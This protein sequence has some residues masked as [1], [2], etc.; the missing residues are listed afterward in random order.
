MVMLDAPPAGPRS[1]AHDRRLRQLRQNAR[2][3]LRL[4]ADVALLT[5]HHASH[6]PV[7]VTA[8]LARAGPGWRHEAAALR[9]QI[10][11]LRALVVALM[12][13]HPHV[14]VEGLL[15]ATPS[16]APSATSMDVEDS[17]APPPPAAASAVPL[18]G[19]PQPVPGTGGPPSSLCI[20]CGGTGK[21][22]WGPC[23]ACALPAASVAPTPSAA[24]SAAAADPPAV[25]RS[26]TRLFFTEESVALLRARRAARL[27][28]EA[29][30]LARASAAALEAE[31]TLV[32]GDVATG[33]ALAEEVRRLQRERPDA[34]AQWVS[35][36]GET[37]GGVMDPL[38][39]TVASLRRFL[40]MV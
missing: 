2:V 40:L 7:L 35:Y 29:A 24:A 4:A 37:L 36:C 22:G 13:A 18:G 28:S 15:P 26:E 12:A 9:E 30:L 16:A 17:E 31:R 32:A 3:R 8:P 39:H 19:P 5:A 14:A 20:A 23:K 38:K 27:E 33:R 34:R 25:P 6:P 1:P 21:G 10:T 11:D